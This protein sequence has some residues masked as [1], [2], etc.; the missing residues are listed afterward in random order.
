MTFLRSI[1]SIPMG[2]V[3]GAIAVVASLLVMWI[4]TLLSRRLYVTI[5]RSQETELLAVYLARIADA[6]ERL[7][8]AGEAR[9]E[10]HVE[11]QIEPQIEH[12][13]TREAHFERP[14]EVSGRR[15]IGM[16]IFGR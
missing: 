4:A 2:Y 10:P 6:L 7:A 9:I 11:R 13:E 8:S 1:V 5:R 14:V 3:V 15:P 12:V 16:S